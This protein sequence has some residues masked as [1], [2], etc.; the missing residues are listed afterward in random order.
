MHYPP[1]LK[2]LKFRKQPV[3]DGEMLTIFHSSRIII[4]E[5]MKFLIR[6][7]WLLYYYGP[8]LLAGSIFFLYF[9]P[10]FLSSFLSF[11]L[12]WLILNLITG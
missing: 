3:R 11:F 9:L 2:L 6:K 7:T 12:G 4:S 1:V 10:F 8:K 5:Q